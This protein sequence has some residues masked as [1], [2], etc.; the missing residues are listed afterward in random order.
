MC[1]SRPTDEEH[2]GRIKT[3]AGVSAVPIQRVH[4]AN[5]PHNMAAAV[6]TQQPAHTHKAG[7]DIA[8]FGQLAIRTEPTPQNLS[9]SCMS[10]DIR[11]FSTSAAIVT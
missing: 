10:N 1:V 6:G 11:A 8:S 7:V 2:S 4:K 5:E 3:H 9:E